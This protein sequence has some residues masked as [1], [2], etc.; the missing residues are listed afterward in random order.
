M[1]R[2]KRAGSVCCTCVQKWLCRNANEHQHQENFE[3]YVVPN[4]RM[5]RRVKTYVEVLLKGQ[6]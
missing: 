1:M 6:N 3:L 2:P 5:G 4:G